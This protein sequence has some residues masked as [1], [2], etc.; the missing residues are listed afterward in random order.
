MPA[1]IILNGIFTLGA[2]PSNL[3]TNYPAAQYPYHIAWCSDRTPLAGYMI[4]NGIE[5]VLPVGPL[6]SVTVGDTM[7]GAPGTEAEVTDTGSMGDVE[8]NFLIPRGNLG[9]EGAPG[10]AGA[11]ATVTVGTVTTGAAGTKATVINSGTASAAIL[12]FKLPQGLDG[13]PGEP[14]VTATIEIGKVT[15]GAPGTLAS[16]VN[17]GSDTTGL[18][19]FTIPR[20]DP[21]AAATV[22]VGTVT[23]GAA[24]SSATVKNSGTSSAA[25]FDFTIPRG[26]P[27]LGTVTPATPTRVLG[28]AF[29][30]STTKATLCIYSVKTQVT[31]PLLTGTSTS[32]VQLLSDSNATPTTE[33]CRGAADSGVGVAVAV[34][35]T[36]ANTSVLAYVVPAGDYVRLVASGTGTHAETL[37]TQTEIALG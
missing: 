3:Q 24:G 34:A 4:S 15:T 20:G 16:V 2:G 18:F 29:R 6:L 22:S 14:G 26:D 11:A 21:G 35:I 8:L 27:G 32:V 28:T 9:D 10:K 36:T 7:T 25:T 13:L 17:E 1:P 31:N 30:P 37:V 19:D 23:T 12:D 5:W 33:R